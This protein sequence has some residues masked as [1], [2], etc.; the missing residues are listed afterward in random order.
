MGTPFELAD[1][2]EKALSQTLQLPCP[3]IGVP[4]K[5]LGRVGSSTLQLRACLAILFIYI[6]I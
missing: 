6:F 1:P 5:P 4:I 3:N 2:K